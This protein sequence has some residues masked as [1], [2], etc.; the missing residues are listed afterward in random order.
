MV[1]RENLRWQILKFVEGANDLVS[2][3]RISE[4]VHA[5]RKE[6]QIQLDILEAQELVNL[7]KTMGPIYSAQITPRG[8]LTLERREAT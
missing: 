6:V 1:S 7:C 5:D 2:D 4:T 3:E 8:R